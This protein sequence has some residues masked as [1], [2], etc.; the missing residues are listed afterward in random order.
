MFLILNC[1]N[2]LTIFTILFSLYFLATPLVQHDIISPEQ[3]HLLFSNVEI[4]R[5]LNETMLCD[6]NK[7]NNNNNN[8]TNN[9]KQETVGEVLG[10]YAPFFKMYNTYVI[11]IYFF[12]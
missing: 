12:H 3:A 6:L 1:N 10:R 2:I 11:I 8:T 7:T 4:L 5:D 9:N